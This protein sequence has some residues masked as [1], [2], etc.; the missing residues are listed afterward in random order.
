MLRS[1]AQTLDRKTDCFL[2]CENAIP[3]L[4]HNPKAK[5]EVRVAW[6]KKLFKS[7]ELVC[8][9]RKNKWGFDVVGRL[10]TNGDAVAAEARYHTKCYSYFTSGRPM[11]SV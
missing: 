3:D 7:L 1:S 2:C 10:T 4:R 9:D 11:P 5:N 6:T 8:E